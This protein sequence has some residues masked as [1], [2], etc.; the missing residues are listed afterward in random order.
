MKSLD[1]G[2]YALC[3]SIAAVMLAGCGA[4]SPIGA[5]GAIAQSRAISTHAERGG[6]WMLPEAM[7]S[8]LLYVVMG[9][10]YTHVLTYPGYKQVAKVPMW[11][12]STSNPNS[13]EVMI[14]GVEGVVKLYEHGAK[15]PIYEFVPPYQDEF[16]RD[17]AFDPTTSNIALTVDTIGAGTSYVVVYQTPSGT[18]AIYAL[19]NIYDANFV[20]YDNQGNLFIDGSNGSLQG[21]LAELPKGGSSFTNITL[22]QQ[23]EKMGSIQWDGSYITVA[24]G[25]SIC[26]LQ[27]SG[28]QAMVVGRTRLDGAW[29]KFGDFWIQ[30]DTAI[31]PHFSGAPHNGRYVGFWHYPAG[32]KAYKVITNLSKRRDDLMVSATISIALTH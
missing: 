4:Q 18:P 20:G 2:R 14:G 17:S 10:S 16:L 32:G 22:N 23:L 13:G 8:D 5:P 27:I 9:E 1:Y 21:V 29:G 26:R 31:G 3:L 25:A 28:S 24:D 12:F 11:G 30:G 15:N 6:S 7:S 19:Q